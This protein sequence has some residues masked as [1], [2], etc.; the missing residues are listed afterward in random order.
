MAEE[1]N[2]AIARAPEADDD[3]DSTKAE[4]QRRMEEAR[5]SITQTVTEIKDTVAN[6]Y[7]AVRHTVTEAL[8]WREQ[9]RK[10]PVAFTVGA[11]SAGFLLGYTVAGTFKGDGSSYEEDYWSIPSEETDVYA[12]T[13]A[14]PA[15]LAQSPYAERGLASSSPPQASTRPTSAHASS[16]TGSY[17]STAYQAAAPVE[18]DYSDS[19]AAED[20]G[21]GLYARFKETR[22]YDKLQEEVSSLGERFVEELSGVAAS[23]VLPA[24]FGKIKDL[25][26]VDL[27]NKQ[28]GGSASGGTS[29]KGVAA[30]GSAASASSAGAGVGSTRQG[31]ASQSGSSY[32]TSENRPYSGSTP[33]QA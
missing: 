16:A 21:P 8:D 11:L 12:R 26:G 3:I 29:A 27:S 1:R 7:Q 22:A 20:K 13:G 33:D 6:Q 31:G 17:G 4:L 24:L 9:Y 25:F 18:A 23:V 5:E 19:S 10:R 14:E 2:L 15:R 30:A 28:R 32:A